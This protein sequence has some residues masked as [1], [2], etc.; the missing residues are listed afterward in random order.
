MRGV[1][2]FHGTL[3][4]SLTVKRFPVE[5]GVDVARSSGEFTQERSETLTEH[6]CASYAPNGSATQGGGAAPTSWD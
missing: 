2:K 1:D 3:R 6:A 5:R 4:H